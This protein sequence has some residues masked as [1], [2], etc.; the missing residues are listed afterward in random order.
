MLGFK[1]T[2][3]GIIPEDW[4]VVRLG[5]V[6]ELI[7]GVSWRK[8]EANKGGVGLPVISI[9]NIGIGTLDFN[10]HHFLTKKVSDQK[11][12]K[13]SDIVF[14]GSSGSIHNVGRNALIKYLPT[15]KIS[16]ASFLALIRVRKNE[17]ISDFLYYLVNS[18]W[19]DFKKFVKRAADG[20]YNFQLR[21]FQD[22]A[23]I[24][25]PPLPE[26]Q[27]IAKV[28][29]T[30][31][32]AIEHQD[33][34]IEATRKLKKSLMHN[35]FTEGLN[36]EEQKETEIGRVPKSWDVVRLGDVCKQRKE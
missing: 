8:D 15:N 1:E 9:P 18:E 7:R 24:P 28:L 27:Q 31:Q 32:C 23:L 11:L 36:G 5:D 2:E 17:L 4:E 22:N 12:L 13:S 3:I 29:S 19:V 26:Q 21:D 25:L 33:K 34:I 20:K 10:F 16:F 14:V 6:A 30:A 35:S